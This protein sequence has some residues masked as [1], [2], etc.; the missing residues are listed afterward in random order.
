MIPLVNT[1]SVALS[2]VLQAGVALLIPCVWWLAVTRRKEPFFAWLG[3]RSPKSDHPAK[4]WGAA[5]GIFA[6]FTVAGLFLVPLVAGAGA[7]SQFAGAGVAGI[8]AVLFYAL[9]QTG[10]AEETLFRGFLLKRIAAR[11]GFWWGNGIQAVVFGGLH[12]VPLAVAV[13]PVGG[14]IVG[15][16]TAAIG[17]SMGWLNEK[18]AG[19]SIV[20]SWALHSSANL[21]V[22]AVALFA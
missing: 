20:P 18:M 9:L 15:V 21:I 10:F 17:L 3:W 13:G 19:G 4:L 12:A 7:A 1:V 22:S 5:A 2:A 11:A 16:F 6:V 14:V 8:P